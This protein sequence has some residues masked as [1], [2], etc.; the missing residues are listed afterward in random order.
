M[1][2][3]LRPSH[4]NVL[5]YVQAKLAKLRR[6]LLDPTGGGGGGGGG[7]AAKGDGTLEVVDLTLSCLSISLSTLV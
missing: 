4:S 5:A 3:V 7:G 6:D 2:I 1:N